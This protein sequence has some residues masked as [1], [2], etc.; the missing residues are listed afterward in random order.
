MV[1]SAKVPYYFFMSGREATPS[2]EV[3]SAKL[4]RFLG[5]WTTLAERL[6]SPYRFD[7]SL[8]RVREDGKLWVTCALSQTFRLPEGLGISVLFGNDADSRVKEKLYDGN[9]FFIQPE[10]P[11]YSNKNPLT[12]VTAIEGRFEPLLHGACP[13]RGVNLIASAAAEVDDYG[14][15]SAD[16]MV[17]H[18]AALPRLRFVVEQMQP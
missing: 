7:T 4:D 10:E 11:G 8:P 6:V 2:I 9:A 17:I 1:S 14:H 18:P 5:I 12:N 15:A 3:V 13:Y 16:I